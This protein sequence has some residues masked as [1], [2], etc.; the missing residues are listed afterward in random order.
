MC[1]FLADFELGK[2]EN[3]YLAGELPKFNF[4]NQQ[5]DLALC[6]HF[7][8]LYSK[9]FSLNFHVNSIKELCR[10]AKEARIFPILELGSKTSRHFEKILEIL[11]GEKCRIE[12]K[13]VPYEFQKGGNKILIVQGKWKKSITS[14]CS[15]RAKSGALGFPGWDEIG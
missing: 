11:T 1:Q 15:C 6:S 10:V 12:I 14:R 5:F 7:L 3:R 13:T 9:Q 4:K 8:F 2:K